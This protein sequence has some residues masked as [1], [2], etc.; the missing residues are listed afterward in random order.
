MS[1]SN[2]PLLNQSA[3]PQSAPGRGVR[4]LNNVPKIFIVSVLVV[5]GGTVIYTFHEREVANRAGIAGS[6]SDKAPVAGS[7]STALGDNPTTG[8][9]PSGNQQPP[10]TPQTLQNQP[11]AKRVLNPIEQAQLQAWQ[12]YEQR[13]EALDQARFGALATAIGA[14]QDVK[15]L[16]SSSFPSESS[17]A[18]IQL[19]QNTPPIGTAGS[20]QMATVPSLDTQTSGQP[21]TSSTVIGDGL[22]RGGLYGSSTTIP[23][24]NPNANDQTGKRNFLAQPGATGSDDVL[25]SRITSPVSPYMVMAGT[26]I[27]A[28]MIGG[29]NSDLPGEIIAQVRQM[30]YDTATGQIPLIPQGARLVG[31]YHSGVSYGQTRVLVAWNRIIYPNG[32]SFDLGTM[33]GA[34][35]GGYAGFNDQV[36]NHYLKVFGTALIASVFSAGAQLSQPTSSSNNETASQVLTAAVGQQ[37]NTVGAQMI[38][39]GLDIQPTLDIR[40]GYRFTVMVT[41]DMVLQ[42][43]SGMPAL[44]YGDPNR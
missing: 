41:K 42:P 18:Q 20:G 27:P 22:L 2:N 11:P 4:R 17:G 34:D 31:V 1:G 16:S 25:A 13:K 8:M 23:G 21:T 3:T 38:A 12:D 5:V 7:A 19:A 39:R 32:Q 36:N 29:I 30:V 15:V 9:I 33:P 10:A 6:D 26:V 35:E 40:N 28:T 14:S 24:A 43:W 44:P 37:A